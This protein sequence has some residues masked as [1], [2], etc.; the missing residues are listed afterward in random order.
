MQTVPYP[1][2]DLFDMAQAAGIEIGWYPSY[3][4]PRGRH[5]AAGGVRAILLSPKLKESAM[6]LRCALAHELG[7]HLAGYYGTPLSLARDEAAAT[8]W[9]QD[10][11]LPDDWVWPRLRMTPGEL[12]DE[13]DVYEIWVRERLAR[14]KMDRRASCVG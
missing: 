11:L 12:A 14:L 1:I 13:A 9:A 4:G 2:D 3:L 10:L 5:I 6:R 8:R 7:H